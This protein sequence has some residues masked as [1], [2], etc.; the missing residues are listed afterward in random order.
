MQTVKFAATAALVIAALGVSTGV[1]YAESPP[2]TS[3][4]HWDAEIA[5]ES[6]VLRTDLGSLT[7]AGDQFRVLDPRGE[8]VTAFPLTFV[9]D[10]LAHPVAARITGNTAVL[11]PNMDPAAATAAP[12]LH[13]V[14]SQADQDA[15]VSA[16]FN[17]FGF[18][19]AIGGM[20]GTLV[21]GIGG[22]AVGALLGTPVLLPGWIGGCLAGAGIG[23]PLGAAAGLVLT[24]VPAAIVVG[25]GLYNRINQPPA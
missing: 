24:G 23:I 15:A 11:T 1:S 25:I 14:A 3:S 20:L 18:A 19:T 16:A 9:S 13:E 21:G 22:C 17:Q 7:T 2:E 6:V 12:L 5:G 10:G 8:L 4:I